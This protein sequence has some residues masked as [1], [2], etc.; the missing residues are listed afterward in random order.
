M[1][2]S[3]EPRTVRIRRISQILLGAIWLTDGALQFQPVMFSKAFVTSVILPN[4]AGQPNVLASPIIWVAHQIEPHVALFNALAASFQVVIGLGLMGKRTV[5]PALAVSFVWALAIWVIGEGL[6]GILNA[7]ADP[8]TGAPGA[9][10][11]YIVVGIMVWP[12]HG[13][14]IRGERLAWAALW[15]TSAVLW[16][17]PANYSP[18]SIHA[19]IAAAPSGAAWLATTL[20]V[21]GNIADGIG[22]PIALTMAVLSVAIALSALTGVLQR[23][24]VALGVALA[25]VCWI[26]GQGLGGVLTG[27]ATDVSAGPLLVLMGCILL[28]HLRLRREEDLDPVM[29]L[30]RARVRLSRLL[31][32]SHE[33]NSVATCVQMPVQIL[34][35]PS[36]A[37]DGARPGRRT[38]PLTAGENP[39]LA[40]RWPSVA[41][42]EPPS[43]LHSTRSRWQRRRLGREPGPADPAPSRRARAFARLHGAGG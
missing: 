43:R 32:G 20:R 23:S 3:G 37:R 27:S 13:D 6:G 42:G 39:H 35:P 12:R 18:N 25:V 4:A 40:R 33:L 2:T 8:L 30:R 31:G 1:A 19:A 22:A 17:M 9:A 7:T 41:E 5:R 36:S 28:A 15:L 16:S 21:V 26:V 29:K 11:L 38:F 10:L 14:G 24:F 34:S